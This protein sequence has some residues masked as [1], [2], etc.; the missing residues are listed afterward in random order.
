MGGGVGLL[1]THTHDYIR[2]GT[3]TLFAPLNHL[4]GKIVSRTE[5]KHTHVDSLRFLKQIDRK[6]PRELEV[7]LIADNYCTQKHEKVKTWLERHPR[8]HKHFTPISGS[9][10][11][12]VDRFFADLT[13]DVVRARSFRSVGQ[14]VKQIELYLTER[15]KTPKPYRW[16][17]IGEEVLAKIKRAHTRI[18]ADAPQQIVQPIC[19]PGHQM[20]EHKC[21]SVGDA[22]AIRATL[23]RRRSCHAGTIDMGDEAQSSR[24]FPPTSEV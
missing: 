21:R 9:W 24:S 7:H 10:M 8:F 2:H 16:R 3:V 22:R 4:N 23:D 1:R 20:A 19:G 13:R 11:N 6:T 18:G 15:N 5:T 14:L 12:L 17:A